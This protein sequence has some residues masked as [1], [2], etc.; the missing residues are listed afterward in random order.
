MGIAAVAICVEYGSPLS[1]AEP[2]IEVPPTSSF[3][4]SSTR[5]VEGGARTWSPTKSRLRGFRNLIGFP[6]AQSVAS[7]AR[8]FFHFL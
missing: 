7:G 4:A 1:V 3:H 5:S 2:G 8:S 6:A